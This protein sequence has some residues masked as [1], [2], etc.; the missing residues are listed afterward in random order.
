VGDT[1]VLGGEWGTV[2]KIGL[3]STVIETFDRAETIVPNSVLIQEQVTNWT[4]TNPISRLV[5]PVGVAYGTDLER[6]L[7][8][9]IDVA[10]SHPKVL[11]WPE[12]SAIFTAFGESSLDCELRVYLSGVEHRLTVRSELGVSIQNRFL[13]EGIE[14]P[15]PQRD[16][17]LRSIDSDVTRNLQAPA[18]GGSPASGD[19]RPKG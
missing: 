10:H 9:L 1:L 18:A 16:L 5:I 7:R 15:F 3:R 17:H 14:I 12:P 4:L 6:V 2:R 8:I 11:K 13:D 19:S